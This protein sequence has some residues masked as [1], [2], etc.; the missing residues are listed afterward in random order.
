M[1]GMA[2]PRELLSAVVHDARGGELL[3]ELVREAELDLAHRIEPRDVFGRELELEATEVF[4]ELRAR[5]GTD[6]R[7]DH[8]RPMA[9][10]RLRLAARN[11]LL[12]DPVE[13]DLR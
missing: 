12:A 2:G 3:Q 5:L 6:Q 7:H 8:A 11:L 10:A 1:R 13:R 4:V 9:F